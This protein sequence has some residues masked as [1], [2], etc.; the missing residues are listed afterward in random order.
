MTPL[1]S[2]RIIVAAILAM[3]LYG[4]IAAMLGTLMP[5]FGFTPAENGKVAGAQALGL[6]IASLAVGP[7][8]DN[9]GKKPALLLGVALIAISLIALATWGDFRL[10]MLCWFFAGM[11]GAIILTAANA[12]GSDASEQRRAIALNLL[13][14]FFGLGGMATPVLMNYLA[15]GS[16]KVL[17]YMAALLCAITF[18]VHVTTPMPRPTGE[19]GFKFSEAHTLL[20]RPSLWLLCAFMFLYVT[21]EVGIWN[22]LV[23]YLKTQ[24]ISQSK[25]L[26]ILSFGF[27]LGLLIGRVIV[28]R[29]LVNV[30]ASTVT[31]GAAGAMAATTFLMLRTSDPA[32][33]GIIVF[34]VGIAMAPVFPTTLAMVA[35]ASPKSTTAMGVVITFGFIGLALSSPLI[36]A[37]AGGDPTAL[38]TGLLVLPV[39]SLIMIVVN[40]ALR[41][42]LARAPERSELLNDDAIGS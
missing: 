29:I 21:C 26:N 1:S 35:D 15:E 34:C 28:C 7:F 31:L 32:L 18:A 9:K 41:P 24:N 17:C 3:F 14:L 10:A 5:G 27:A 16:G 25:A 22:W 37:I 4:I 33:A 38:K 39:A 6:V 19:R 36:G 20:G 40:L 42:L 11:G 2:G 8:I 13:S 23:L 30:A 12:L